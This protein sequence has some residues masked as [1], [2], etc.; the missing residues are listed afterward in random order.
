MGWGTGNIGSGSGGLNFKVIGGTSAPTSPKENMIWVNTDADITGYYFSATEPEAPIEGMVWITT[1]ATS[2]VEFNALKKNGIQVYPISAMQYE[3]G[4]WVDKTAK[5]YQGGVWVDW[6]R[7][8]YN[9]GNEYTEL[10]GGW[11]DDVVGTKDYPN[12]PTCV[13]NADSLTAY[14]NSGTGSGGWA[15]VNKIDFTDIKTLKVNV[16]E[17]S[18][19]GTGGYFM[20]A[21]GT[22]RYDVEHN[23]VAVY[24]VATPSPGMSPREVVLSTENVSGEYYVC[25]FMYIYQ[26]NAKFTFDRVTFE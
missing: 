22:Q 10:T 4:A 19:S 16:T 5:S 2:S 7:Y 11:T 18:F 26:G 6:I 13:R 25:V 14:I 3:G 17:A 20:V 8:L 1:G 12:K 21:L 23:N 24:H 15:T 9:L